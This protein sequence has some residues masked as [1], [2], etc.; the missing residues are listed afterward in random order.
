M[1][2]EEKVRDLAYTIWE[3]EGRPEGKALEHY[4]TA[5]S[6]LEE[7]ESANFYTSTPSTSSAP[8]ASAPN[9]TSAASAPANPSINVAPES[10]S[11]AR[12]ASRSANR[13][14]S[15]RSPSSP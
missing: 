8:L 10:K 14:D 4:Y 7:Q 15:W 11:T 9:A 6:L 12:P 13:R 5:R 1:V 3:Q 2:A